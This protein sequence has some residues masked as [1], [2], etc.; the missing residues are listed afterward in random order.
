MDPEKVVDAIES[1]YTGKLAKDIKSSS[2]YALSG[3]MFG[4]IGGVLIASFLGQSKLIF[5]LGGA[6]VAGIAGYVIAKK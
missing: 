4:A 1:V 5:G 3:V 2:S 6:A